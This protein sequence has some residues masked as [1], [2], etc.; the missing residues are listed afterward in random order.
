MRGMDEHGQTWTDMDNGKIEYFDADY[1]D[2][3]DLRKGVKLVVGSPRRRQKESMTNN[4]KSQSTP[5]GG[6][7]PG[8][9]LSGLRL[10]TPLI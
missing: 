3:T 4:R 5:N 6:H 2:Y 7:G 8:Y 10:P 9:F 1:A